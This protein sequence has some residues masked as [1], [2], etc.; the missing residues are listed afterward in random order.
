MV[1]FDAVG[2]HSLKG[3]NKTASAQHQEFMQPRLNAALI[4]VTANTSPRKQI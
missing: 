4:N 2:Q 1:R 3:D